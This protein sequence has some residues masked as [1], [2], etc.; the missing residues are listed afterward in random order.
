MRLYAANVTEYME[1]QKP[2]LNFSSIQWNH[3]LRTGQI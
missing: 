3:P 2:A 1:P